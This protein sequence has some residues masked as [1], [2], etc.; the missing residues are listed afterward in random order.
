MAATSAAI[1][2]WA[3]LLVL[4]FLGGC[5]LLFTYKALFPSPKIHVSDL[6]VL[7][8]AKKPWKSRAGSLANY[9]PYLGLG[10]LLL[11]FI[12]PR[13]YKLEPQNIDPNKPLD[14]S[15]ATQGIA[16]YLVLDQSGSMVESI[17]IM[18]YDELPRKVRKK[19]FANR[20]RSYQ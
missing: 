12:D 8:T 1:D 6:T 9:L 13:F 2:L 10:F 19:H 20:S 17:N 7:E 14:S 3:L 16:I 11:A 4:L 5:Y 18:G 15:L